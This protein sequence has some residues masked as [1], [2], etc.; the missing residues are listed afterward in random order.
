M[1]K[2]AV[3]VSLLTAVLACAKVELP[4]VFSTHAVLARHADVPVWG[5]ASPGEKVTVE[6]NKQKVST[7]AGKDG[8]WKVSLNLLH[9][10]EGPFV[11]KVNE[12]KIKDVVV[13]EVWLGSGQSNMAM[14]MRNAAGFEE[15]QK[16]LPNKKL[17]MFVVRPGRNE[18]P[19]E[20]CWG[21]WRIADA[22]T[23]GSFSAASYFFGKNNCGIQ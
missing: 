17:R 21:A 2:F 1:K 7:V 3:C 19:Q 11:L 5:K 13:G 23:L 6:F 22:K 14:V 4:S 16:G 12:I 8:K 18:E 10:P 15:E 20:N 9:S